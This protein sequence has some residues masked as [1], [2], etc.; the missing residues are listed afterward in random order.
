MVGEPSLAHPAAC[1]RVQCI[2]HAYSGDDQNR[3]QH[4]DCAGNEQHVVLDL[5]TIP[6]SYGLQRRDLL[7]A[8]LDRSGV[9]LGTAPFRAGDE[10]VKV[11]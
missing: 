8:V 4:D 11:L 6:R 1:A 10:S 2:W 9:P 5:A 7:A 3:D